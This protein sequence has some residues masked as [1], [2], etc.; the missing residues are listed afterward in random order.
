[1]AMIG[2]WQLSSWGLGGGNGERGRFCDV[3]EVAW[4]GFI[5]SL[6]GMLD[7]V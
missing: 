7:M 4:K 2:D 5:S 1:M 3:R 6:N